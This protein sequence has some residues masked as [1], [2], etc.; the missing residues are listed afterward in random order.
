MDQKLVALICYEEDSQNV[1]IMPNV[2]IFS[3]SMA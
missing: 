1:I 2:D 3:I